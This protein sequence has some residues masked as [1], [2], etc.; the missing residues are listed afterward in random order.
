MAFDECLPGNVGIEKTRESLE[1]TTRWAKRSRVRF[2]ELQS[3]GADTG[4]LPATGKVSG[5]QALFGILQG[6]GHPELRKESLERTADIG[7]DG[8]AIGGLSVGEDKT[9]MYSV[10]E[11]IA[12]RM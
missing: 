6:A 7:F 1:L 2:D 9:V 5:A 8:Y 10:L 3:E 12:P 4:R 11:Y